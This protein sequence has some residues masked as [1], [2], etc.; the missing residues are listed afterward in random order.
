MVTQH[1]IYATVNMSCITG[2]FAHD[3]EQYQTD[4]TNRVEYT[5]V[6]T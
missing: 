3:Q 5:N 1:P 4:E 2:T 6:Y